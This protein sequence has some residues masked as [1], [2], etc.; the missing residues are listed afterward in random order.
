MCHSQ[1]FQIDVRY[2]TEKNT[3]LGH[4]DLGGKSTSIWWKR[5]RGKEEINRISIFVLFCFFFWFSCAFNA[6]SKQFSFVFDFSTGPIECYKL[7]EIIH[8]I[9]LIFSI[10]Y[11]FFSKLHHQFNGIKS[12][13]LTLSDYIYS[14][15]QIV[16]V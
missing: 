8:I 2:T 10:F 6:L 5:A 13:D 14:I 15:F 4:S 16:F 7:T 3:I 1:N 11:F 9:F 12:F